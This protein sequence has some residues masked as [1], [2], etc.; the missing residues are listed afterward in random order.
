MTPLIYSEISFL[1]HH[2]KWL[3]PPIH[4]AFFPYFSS[5][6]NWWEKYILTSTSFDTKS[7]KLSRWLICHRSEYQVICKNDGAL[8]SHNFLFKNLHSFFPFIAREIIDQ[9]KGIQ[10]HF[11]DIKKTCKI[12]SEN[13]NGNQRCESRF[14]KMV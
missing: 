6:L 11:P 3:F 5:C 1:F 10:F 12:N 4:V 14:F 9:L 8:S 13:G 2:N 7:I